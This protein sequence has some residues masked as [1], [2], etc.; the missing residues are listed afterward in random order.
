[1]HH[2]KWN[3]Q[4]PPFLRLAIRQQTGVPGMT[5][6]SSFDGVVDL[7]KKFLISLSVFTSD[8]D[9]QR[10]FAALQRLEMFS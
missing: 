10:N 6:P 8:E 1:M 9:L 7:D 3:I 2:M 5:H 4:N